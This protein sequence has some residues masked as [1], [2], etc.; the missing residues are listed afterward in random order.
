MRCR[1][2]LLVLSAGL[3]LA[4]EDGTGP[5]L[6][7]PTERFEPLP[8]Y[9]AWWSLVE[10]CSGMRGDLSKVQWRVA[11][12]RATF[13]WQGAVTNGLW[14]SDG[15]TIVLGDGWQG[16]GAVVRH[17]MLHALAR[18]GGHQA[19][20]FLGSCGDIVTCAGS[21]LSDSNSQA[22]LSLF[23]PP[24][25]IGR[26]V[27]DPGLIEIDV[28]VTPSTV[29]AGSEAQ[30]WTTITVMAR[31]RGNDTVLVAMPSAGSPGPA[32]YTHFG[33]RLEGAPPTV[34]FSERHVIFGAGQVRRRVYELNAASTPGRSGLPPGDYAIRGIFG[35]RTTAPVTLRVTP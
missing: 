26:P 12:G 10:S 8:P 1:S 6:R 19:E 30:S 24:L 22:P 33:W 34:E 35:G 28:L 31:H 23:P 9:A 17:E 18:S 21:C 3:V 32:R 7:F 13:D 20:L 5:V 29:S 2:R 25:L 15:N 4:C 14:M 27:I 16:T 11:R